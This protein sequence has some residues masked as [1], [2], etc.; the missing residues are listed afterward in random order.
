MFALPTT[1]SLSTLPNAARQL[2][3]TFSLLLLLPFGAS[4]AAIHACQT[5]DGSTVFQDRP[6]DI[7]PAAAAPKPSSQKLPFGIHESW[8]EIPEQADDRAFC[9]RRLCECGSHVR[10]HEGGLYRA[11]ADALFLDAS[12]HRFDTSLELWMKTP[13][14]DPA[15]SQLRA[16]MIDA[17]C[18][19][20][21]SQQ[22]LRDFARSTAAGLRKRVLS[23]EDLGFD[24]P[25]PCD[26][27]VAQAC[28]YYDSVLL[29]KRLLADAK[30][31]KYAR[32]ALTTNLDEDL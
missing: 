4:N 22:L 3:A 17:S 11:V 26:A 12:W 6:C 31:L 7:K 21:M 15:I 5:A 29:Y 24:I 20:M 8:F 19:I 32:D 27:G 16:E 18:S 30:A 28:D 23:A 14:S 9:D 13:A 10:S 25:E 2:L 1:T